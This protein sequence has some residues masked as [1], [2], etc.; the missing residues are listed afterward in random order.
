MVETKVERRCLKESNEVISFT[1][2]F[3]TYIQACISSLC[4]FIM[5]GACAGVNFVVF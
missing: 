4:V 2:S 5:V 3:P 1:H